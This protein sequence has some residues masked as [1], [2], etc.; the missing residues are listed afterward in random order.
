MTT[1]NSI[2]RRSTSRMTGVISFA[3]LA[4]MLLASGNAQAASQCKG[5]EDAACSQNA[6]CSWVQAYE[7]KDGRK[8]S[9]FCRTKAKTAQAKS[10]TRNELATSE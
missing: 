7:R 5:L 8:V 4:G 9:A 10:K 3:L 6:S 1:F 2:Q